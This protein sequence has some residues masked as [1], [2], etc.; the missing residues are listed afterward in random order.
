MLLSSFAPQMFSAAVLGNAVLLT[1]FIIS[2]ILWPFEALPY[3]IRPISYIQPSTIPTE[4]IRSI[5]ARGLSITHP[6]VYLGFLVSGI[7]AFVFLFAAI[8]VFSRI[9]TA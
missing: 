3:W 8:F 9:I 4:S 1:I 5:L 6:S 7:W 2:G